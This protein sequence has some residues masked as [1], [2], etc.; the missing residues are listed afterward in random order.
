MTHLHGFSYGFSQAIMFFAYAASFYAG[1]YFV[2]EGIN[3]YEDIYKYV[4]F[5]SL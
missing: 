1:A 3:E 5:Y 4:S 2:N